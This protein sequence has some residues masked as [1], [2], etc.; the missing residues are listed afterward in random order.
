MCGQSYVGIVI[1]LD[2]AAAASF[3]GQVLRQ[4]EWWTESCFA[5]IASWVLTVEY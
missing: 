5:S 2:W 3:G 4:G 1:G